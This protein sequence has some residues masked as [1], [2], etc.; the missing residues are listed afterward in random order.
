MNILKKRSLG[1][2][3]G[4]I[5]QG[6]RNPLLYKNIGADGIKTGYLS[7]EKYSLASSIIRN[8]RRLIAVGSG[9]V[10]KNSRSKES[11]KLLTFGLTN[12][13]TIKIADNNETFQ[14]LEVR[15]GF[16]NK[17]KT[18]VKKDIYKKILKAKKKYLKVVVNYDGPI[19]APIKKDDVLADLKIYFKDELIS[20]YKL[21]SSEDIKK[22]NIISRLISSINFLIWGDV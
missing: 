9:F 16:K 10:S 17:V 1:S 5:T 7:Y 21:Y 22:Q 6:N 20:K 2:N 11:L 19:N 8:K 15:H 12:F 13:D 4:I 14:E 18:Y 3:G